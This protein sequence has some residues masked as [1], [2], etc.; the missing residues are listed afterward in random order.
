M[1]FSLIA[2]TAN[3][4][5]VVVEIPHAGL[6][7]VATAVST[8]RAP[9][10]ALGRDADLYVDSLY[11]GAPAAG[12]TLLVAHTSRYVIDLNRSEADI[13]ADAVE[14]A[15]TAA[16]ASRGLVWRVTGDG[17]KVL[18]RRL[19]RAE[20]DERLEE[21]Y[22]P[23]HRA[24]RGALDGKVAR[25]GRAVLLAAHSMPSASRVPSTSGAE[26]KVARADVVPGSRGRTSANE[27]FIDAV[28]EHAT[29]RGW[30]VRHDEPYRGGFVTAHYGRPRASVHAVQVELARR[31]YMDEQSLATRPDQFDAVRQ[32]CLALVA[33]LGELALR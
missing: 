16:R 20:L 15:S 30:T 17:D 12:A 25:F 11:A 32:W 1:H 19:S 4:T 7:L 21:I 2:P 9:I 18:T 33:K 31:L 13:D 27:R 24:L 6:G 5:P 14:G 28:E 8:L 22:R 3:E 23:Y 29:G 26:G 10:H